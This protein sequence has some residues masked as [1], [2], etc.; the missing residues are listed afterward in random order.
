MAVLDY[1]AVV[2]ADSPLSYHKMDEGSGNL[3]DS[4]GNGF[5]LTANG[6]LT[7]GEPSII[8][9]YS[10][11]TAVAFGSS[12][13]NFFDSA[14]T[15][16]INGSAFT[17]EFF[18]QFTDTT[19]VHYN[20]VQVSNAFSCRIKA[21]S[22]QFRNLQAGSV[23]YA[24]QD[25]IPI[26]TMADGNP[27]HVVFRVNG[28]DLDIIV[29]GE[30]WSTTMST[31]LGNFTNEVLE[32]GGRIDKTVSHVS[33]Y[34]TAL[35][36]ERITQ[37]YRS[38]RLMDS[39]DDIICA[40]TTATPA[41]APTNLGTLASPLDI[42][43]AFRKTYWIGT[44]AKLRMRNDQGDYVPSSQPSIRLVGTPANRIVIEPY[45]LTSP[46]TVDGV[47]YS[48]ADVVEWHED[49]NYVDLKFYEGKNT[50]TD[51][52]A[53]V[54]GVGLWFKAPN[55]RLIRGIIHDCGQGIFW[56]AESVNSEIHGTLLYNNGLWYD[57]QADTEKG[58]NIYVQNY[59]ASNRKFAKSNCSWGSADYLWQWWGQSG[60]TW[61]GT[62]DQSLLA[63]T[64]R[65]WGTDWGGVAGAKNTGGIVHQ[66]YRPVLSI[67][68]S[69]LMIYA[70]AD[71]GRNGDP[72]RDWQITDSLFIGK[73]TFKD[74]SQFTFSDNE[75]VLTSNV[76]FDRANDYP[77][78]PTHQYDGTN[79]SLWV[80]DGNTWYDDNLSATSP[81][82]WDDDGFGLQNYNS[83]VSLVGETNGTLVDTVTNPINTKIRYAWNDE[84]IGH[85]FIGVYNPAGNTNVT[86]DLSGSGLNNG[87]SYEIHDC[88]N[89]FGT[90]VAS[91]IFNSGSPTVSLPM[92]GT[93][94]A[95]P[96]GRTTYNG[97]ASDRTSS[98][99]KSFVVSPLEQAAGVPDDPTGITL[100]RQSNGT[101]IKIDWTLGAG[102]AETGVTLEYSIDGGSMQ[103]V[104]F[105]AGI[106]TY[107]ITGLSP[108]YQ[109]T[110]ARVKAYNGSGD[111][112]YT[113]TTSRKF[114]KINYFGSVEPTIN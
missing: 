6:I 45:D 2:L 12:S 73:I 57:G 78:V 87:Q 98:E 10:G 75:I 15:F 67:T 22:P 41:G 86:V 84:W 109:V 27:H 81:N 17:V 111:S 38:A 106:E 28:T 35:S 104:D 54:R 65:C 21:K 82:S 99:F 31:S 93:T 58:H 16:S 19:N 92:T 88:M 76:S 48:T 96:V 26:S 44:G 114:P 90:A 53:T 103:S 56:G 108:P 9:A 83:W 89:P 69:N 110:Y 72:H 36:D 64:G 23:N 49:S 42:N 33:V 80:V 5:T 14:P 100:T 102:T 8:D 7:Y 113:A 55:C 29:D 95:A 112:G 97:T 91:G 34:N 40:P 79:K 62:D 18:I 3:V 25:G 105:G 74:L 59:S 107:T 30:I 37:H 85:G 50:G 77:E 94:V 11:R 39:V 68:K 20:I 61:Q 71:F 43:T 32:I 4:S 101:E 1:D 24:P 52:S 47:N 70:N 46:F 66:S 51:R 60:D 63:Y 13:S